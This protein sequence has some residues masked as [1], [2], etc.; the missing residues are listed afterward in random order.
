MYDA[1]GGLRGEASYVIGKLLGRRHC[2]L[3]DITHS[4]VRRRP[5]WDAMVARLGLSLRL[6]HLNELTAVEREVVDEVDAPVVLVLGEGRPRPLLRRDELESAG[7]DL[8][9]F[10]TLLTEALAGLR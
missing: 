8:G 9:R 1:D 3:C 7:G 5:E 2:S 10:E 6:A 4:P